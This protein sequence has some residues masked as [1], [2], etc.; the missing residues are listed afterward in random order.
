MP[1]FLVVDDEKEVCEAFEAALSQNGYSVQSCTSGARA[2]EIFRRE[3]V[4]LVFCD[5]NL[6]GLNGL[7]VLESMK[8]LDP[9]AVII[10]VTAYGSIETA[11]HALRLGA[12]DFLEKPCTID[13]IQKVTQQALEHRRQLHQLTLLQG[14]PESPT[15][16]PDRLTELEQIKSDFFK[17]AVQELRAPLKI[18]NETLDLVEKGFYG[19]WLDPPKQQF[20][21]QFNRMESLLSRTF[22]G[23]LAFFLTHEYQVTTARKD[24]RS[25]VEECVLKA[26][27]SAEEHHIVFETTVP[28]D[29]VV[30]SSDMEKIAHIIRE[31]LENAF[32]HTPAGGFVHLFLTQ[33]NQEG[34]WLKVKNSGR[35][36]SE[37]EKEWLFTAFR[38]LET[39][40]AL[41]ELKIGSA[42]IRYYV[43]LLN[44]KIDL[45][46][47]EGGG[48]CITLFLPWRN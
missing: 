21:K 20:L 6:A 17:L 8:A 29:P 18:L 45:Q 9:W 7:K 3:R 25:I 22:L 32:S 36:I 38:N 26:K 48:N 16:F 37:E 44:G 10:M 11:T 4:D 46:K 34:F 41:S 2:I 47:E 33:E 15:D 43:D 5:L 40:R 23:C 13:Q 31:L 30:G 14:T 24:V 39:N 27:I 28:K 35:T 1:K 19:S 42:L 12:Y